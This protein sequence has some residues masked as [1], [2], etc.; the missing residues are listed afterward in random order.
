MDSPIF[1]RYNYVKLIGRGMKGDVYEVYDNIYYK[2]YA[3]IHGN[4][5]IGPVA[6]IESHPFYFVTWY[7]Y[8]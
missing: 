7:I 3:S 6:S 8:I 5:Y 4:D 2:L 1:N